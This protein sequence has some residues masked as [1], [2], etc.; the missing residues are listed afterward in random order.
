MSL[1]LTQFILSI[2][3]TK[4]NTKCKSYEMIAVAFR[5]MSLFWWMRRLTR[6]SIETLCQVVHKCQHKP[7]RV[8]G[9]LNV[10]MLD[11]SK[12]TFFRYSRPATH[13]TKLHFLPQ[14]TRRGW[15]QSVLSSDSSNGNSSFPISCNPNA[16]TG[17][18]VN[19]M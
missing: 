3:T 18:V 11:E 15:T 4:T 7:H 2:G 10:I 8:Y 1:Y 19:Q 5:F 12:K 9:F 6:L 16:A 13:G 14:V 17:D